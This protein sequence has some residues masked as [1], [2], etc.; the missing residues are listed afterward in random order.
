MQF[1]TVLEAPTAKSAVF[2]GSTDVVVLY[3]DVACFNTE[4]VERRNILVL[5]KPTIKIGLNPAIGQPRWYRLRP[6]V[7]SLLTMMTKPKLLAILTVAGLPLLAQPPMMGPGQLDQVVQRIAL[8]PD[9]LLAQILTASTFWNDIPDAA[10][11]SN[12]HDNLNSDD[13][14]AAISADRLPWDPSVLAL[15]PFPAVLNM[16]ASDRGWTETLGN[17]VLQ[18]RGDVMDAVQRM[19]QRAYDYGYLRTNSYYRVVAGGPGL[20]EIAP[21]GAGYYYVPRYD[22]LIVYAAPRPGFFVGG[23]IA[24]GPRIFI[25]ASFGRWGWAGPGFG[26]R[27]HEILIDHRPWVRTYVNRST[28]VHTYSTPY[29]RP[30]A[31]R[32]ESHHDLHSGSYHEHDHHR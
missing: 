21:V 26:W 22:P 32:V 27:T 15:L 1:S 30:E 28:Y 13:M 29:H 20:I 5:N 16:M 14:A 3:G 24:F 4:I 9:P 17:A 31:A 2:N 19:R 11:W 7:S 12:Q 23:A 18:Q 8:Y 25:G 6:V 10:G